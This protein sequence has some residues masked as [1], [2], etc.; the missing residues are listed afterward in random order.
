MMRK[1]LWKS[2]LLVMTTGTL[3]SWGL[4]SNGCLKAMVQRIL[5]DVAF[6]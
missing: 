4:G 3:L 6:D 2:A 5:V 1:W